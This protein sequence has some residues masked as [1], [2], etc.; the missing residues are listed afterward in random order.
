ME[1]FINEICKLLVHLAILF[2]IFVDHL[3]VPGKFMHSIII[4]LV[5]CKGGDLADVNIGL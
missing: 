3:Y 5:K 1:A 4:L 2:T